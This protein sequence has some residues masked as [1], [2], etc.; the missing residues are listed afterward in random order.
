MIVYEGS[1]YDVV[2]ISETTDVVR[3]RNRG[4]V[5]ILA[6]DPSKK[7]IVLVKQYR[8]AVECDIVDLPAGKLETGESPSEAALR[9]FSEETG[10]TLKNIKH[11]HSYNPTVGLSNSILH[12]FYGEFDKDDLSKQ[13]LDDDERIEAIYMSI[14][15]FINKEE[16]IGHNIIAQ[17]YLKSLL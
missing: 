10:H 13:S 7:E 6:I 12:M 2:K 17:Y 4:A 5:V 3:Y 1:I 14:Y 8:P 11:L 15:D 16:S 9:E